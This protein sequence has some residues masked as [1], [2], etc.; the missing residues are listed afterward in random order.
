MNAENIQDFFSFNLSDLKKKMSGRKKK[1]VICCDEKNETKQKIEKQLDELMPFL[2]KGSLRF[3]PC[4]G[5]KNDVP[6]GGS[7][8]FC[9]DKIEE[10]G[11]CPHSYKHELIQTILKNQDFNADHF[12]E[13]EE[14]LDVNEKHNIP[15]NLCEEKFNFEYIVT[16][17]YLK[18]EVPLDEF[19]KRLHIYNMVKDDELRTL[20]TFIY[21][22]NDMVYYLDNPQREAHDLLITTPTEQ[23]ENFTLIKKKLDKYSEP[24]ET[25]EDFFLVE[26]N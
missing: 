3:R 9:P 20:V 15:T 21:I 4:H 23:H 17:L 6:L 16:F 11:G 26:N 13:D 25:E 24:L 7:H 14:M 12:N 10:N 8:Y 18:Q 1:R 19:I 22:E 2:S 5:C